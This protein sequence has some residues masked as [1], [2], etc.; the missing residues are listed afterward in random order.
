MA[1]PSL[2]GLYSAASIIVI[3]WVLYHFVFYPALFSPLAQIPTPHWTCSISDAWISIARFR[4]RENRTLLAAHRR[5]GQ[6][7]R[8]G[9]REL[10]VNSMQAVKIIYQGGFDK[11]SWYSVFDNFG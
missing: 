9:P 1:F 2:I 8:V 11:H 5:C 4:S 6:I 7:V 3:L 10:S